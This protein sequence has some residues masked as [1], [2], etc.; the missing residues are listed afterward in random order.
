M[1][2]QIVWFANKMEAK[3]AANDHKG[4]W[5]WRDMPVE[6]FLT[7]MQEESRE[8]SEAIQ[9]QDIEATINECA[10]LAN[11]AMMLADVVHR[12]GFQLLVAVV[13]ESDDTSQTE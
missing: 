6:Y 3:L 13:A 4:P 7:R 10:D 8:L 11:F 2:K 1:R 5:G 12:Y 9:S